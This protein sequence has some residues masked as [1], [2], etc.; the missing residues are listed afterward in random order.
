[1]VQSK[2]MMMITIIT[3]IIFMTMMMMMMKGIRTASHS[4][5]S[6]VELHVVVFLHNFDLL[7]GTS[8]ET[9]K[10]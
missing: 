4:K 9:K 8:T 2:M 3:I 5:S 7:N 10:Y 6:E 1:M